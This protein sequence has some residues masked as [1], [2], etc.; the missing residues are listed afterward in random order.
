MKKIFQNTFVAITGI[1]LIFALA[2]TFAMAT[3]AQATEKNSLEAQI[4]DLTS[5]LEKVFLEESSVSGGGMVTMS[6]LD[7]TTGDPMPS[8][9]D[10]YTSWDH[11]NTF[12]SDAQW[13]IEFL[14]ADW[15]DGSS[16][17]NYLDEQFVD[18]NGDGLSDYIYRYARWLTGATTRKDIYSC[19][20]L[21][22]G[23]GFDEAYK[24]RAI[25]YLNGPQTQNYYGDCADIS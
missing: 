6:V 18:L 10:N 25:I 23:S 22:N 15:D 13:G 5:T 7:I 9:I 3:F 1:F 4:S 12:D 2:F 17:P 19:V 16:T 14:P 24:C 20:L 21:N 11:S 8:C